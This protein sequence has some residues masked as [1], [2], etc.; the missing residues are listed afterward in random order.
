MESWQIQRVEQLRRVF[1]ASNVLPTF[2]LQLA[3]EIEIQATG[4][5]GPAVQL[6][7]SNALRT[8]RM[9]YYPVEGGRD[10]V[11]VSVRNDADGSSFLLDD[12]MRYQGMQTSPNPFRP[13]SHPGSFDEQLRAVLARFESVICTGAMPALL[14]GE[15]WQDVPFDWGNLK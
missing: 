5:L 12:W 6:D 1:A 13:G 7:F 14:R 9:M 11:L 4:L 3:R 15:A 8:V 2:G 10:A